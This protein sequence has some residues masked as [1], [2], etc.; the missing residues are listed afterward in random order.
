MSAVAVKWIYELQEDYKVNL[1]EYF[2]ERLE[3]PCAFEDRSGRTRLLLYPDGTAIIKAGYAWDGC[4]PKF[5]VFDI[6]LGTPDGVPNN[7]TRKPKTYYASLVHDVL[8]QFLDVELPIRR[9]GADLAFRNIMARDAF[10][11][12][13]VYWPA[14]RLLGG[15]FRLFTRWKR[16][17]AGRR[18]T[19]PEPA[20]Q[21]AA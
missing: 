3:H 21:A 17:Y 5:A 14:V 13:Y 18:V 1:L 16:S 20:F 19:L 6:L 7:Q 9:V 4:T 12:R 2:F 11:P 8:Y 10:A 15:A